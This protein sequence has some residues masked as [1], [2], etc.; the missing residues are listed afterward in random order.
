MLKDH[1]KSE[2]APQAEAIAA[3]TFI[4][5]ELVMKLIDEKRLVP[6][7]GQTVQSFTHHDSCHAK[8]HCGVSKQP[9]QALQ[10]VGMELK[11]MYECD[12]C[13]G[14][15][16]SYTLKEPTISMRMLERKLQNIADTKADFVTVECPGCLIQISGGLDKTESPTKA[17]HVAELLVD[18]FK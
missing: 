18:K 6:K 11:E 10:S 7:D 9:R 2:L 5:S 8:R 16:G 17:R 4:F 1:G 12:T 14:M 13:C 15:G 3:K